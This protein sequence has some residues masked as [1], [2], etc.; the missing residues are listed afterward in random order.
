MIYIR[1]PIAAVFLSLSPSSTLKSYSLIVGTV[2][3]FKLLIMRVTSALSALALTASTFAKEL[4]K[5]EELGACMNPFDP[6]LI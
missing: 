1:S 6:D 5:D 4:P 2:S 3:I